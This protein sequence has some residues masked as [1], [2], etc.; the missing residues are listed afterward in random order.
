MRRIV[1]AVAASLVLLAIPLHATGKPA[2][3]CI[4]K[5][6]HPQCQPQPTA[7]PTG[8]WVL[9]FEDTFDQA[10]AE[11]D[12][13]ATNTLTGPWGSYPGWHDTFGYSVWDS[14]QTVSAA[15]GTLRIRLHDGYGAAIIP[16]TP[17]IGYGVRNQLYGRY[18]IRLRATGTSDYGLAYLLWPKS[19]VWPRDG[20]IDFPEGRLGGTIHGF[21]HH[22]GATSGGDQDAYDTGAPFTDW[23]TTVIEWTPGAV[24]LYLDGT[25]IGR[26]TERVPNT[27]MRLTLQSE[28]FAPPTTEALI[29]LDSV[30]VWSYAP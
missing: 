7:S 21:V 4:R 6:T 1:A 18:E 27:P 15:N 30:R 11:G 20:E 24:A 3:F 29:E 9:A 19:E 25:L 5:A 10:I 28:S 22:Q 14:S 23:H 16:N 26:T 13:P 2:D 17:D 8:H 12:F